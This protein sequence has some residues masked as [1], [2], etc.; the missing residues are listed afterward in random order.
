MIDHSVQGKEKR[1]GRGLGRTIV[2]QIVAV[3]DG[4]VW[5]KAFIVEFVWLQP[6][7]ITLTAE[8]RRPK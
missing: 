3:H 7:A 1:T 5:S 2:R 8:N 4:Y 6:V